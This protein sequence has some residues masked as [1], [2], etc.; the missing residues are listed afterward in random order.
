MNYKKYENSLEELNNE[1]RNNV[2]ELKNKEYSVTVS[3]KDSEGKIIDIRRDLTISEAYGNRYSNYTKNKCI[4]DSVRKELLI[5]KEEYNKELL[6]RKDK[7]INNFLKDL[8]KEV[9]INVNVLER[10]IDISLKKAV[11]LNKYILS[12]ITDSDGDT[13]TDYIQDFS[14]ESVKDNINMSKYLFEFI[15]D[16]VKMEV[17]LMRIS[18]EI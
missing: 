13:I 18:K 9:N 12:E 7:A 8:A 15:E 6:L 11:V 16:L 10:I 2:N 3:L 14:I 17:E 4:N 1:Y 5:I